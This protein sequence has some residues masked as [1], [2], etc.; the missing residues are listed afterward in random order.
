[1]HPAV[2]MTGSRMTQET[3][4]GSLPRMACSIVVPQASSQPGY[5]QS[6]LAAVAVGRHGVR[7]PG[8]GNDRVGAASE[9]AEARAPTGRRQCAEGRAVVRPPQRDDLVAAALAV[10]LVVL[11]SELDRRFDRLGAAVAEERSPQVARRQLGEPACQL[12]GDRARRPV[13]A[14]VRQPLRLLV[15]RTRDLLAAVAGEHREDAPGKGVEVLAAVRVVEERSFATFEHPRAAPGA[16][17][18]SASRG[19]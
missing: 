19:R 6:Q 2:A 9:D 16:A 10:R 12:D 4:S 15:H 14:G 1:M 17:T 18:P 5:A 8:R 7:V 11:A 13:R 3:S